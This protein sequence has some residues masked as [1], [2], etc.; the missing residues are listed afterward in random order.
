LPLD[1]GGEHA[2]DG[3]IAQRLLQLLDAVTTR[4]ARQTLGR[5]RL[6]MTRLRLSL[7]ARPQPFTP[8]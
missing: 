1:P 3:E 7:G 4:Q 8:P 5:L 6:I 2:P